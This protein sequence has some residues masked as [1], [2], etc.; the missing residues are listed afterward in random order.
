MAHYC[1]IDACQNG[2]S[3]L[4]SMDGFASCFCVSGWTGEL[5]DTCDV[6]LT[7]V[8]STNSICYYGTE[9][10]NCGYPGMSED[11]CYQEEC[12][13]D[14]SR[15]DQHWCFRPNV[16]HV[17]RCVENSEIGDDGDEGESGDLDEGESGDSVESEPDD[18]DCTVVI[19]SLKE[20]SVIFLIFLCEK[21]W[22]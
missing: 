7:E 18:F 22:K 1:S 14:S 19:G 16:Y 17:S 20:F 10:T 2:G 11:D 8:N 5:C 21:H 15:P 9:R 4:V 13:W 12:C 6:G 3:C